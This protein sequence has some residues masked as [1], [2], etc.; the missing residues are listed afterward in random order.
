MQINIPS[1]VYN[2]AQQVCKI[3]KILLA[4]NNDL[5]YMPQ[6][7]SKTCA[8]KILHLFSVIISICL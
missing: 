5:V 1:S 3:Y 6:V 7:S 4:H 8:V 2:N